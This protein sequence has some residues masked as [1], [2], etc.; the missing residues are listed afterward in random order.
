VMRA[1]AAPL[2]RKRGSRRTSRTQHRA[3]GRRGSARHL[4]VKTS[5]PEL[6]VI[7]A[8][9]GDDGLQAD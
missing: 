1:V 6:P 3:E 2:G 4:P 7:D 8:K 5:P 9:R